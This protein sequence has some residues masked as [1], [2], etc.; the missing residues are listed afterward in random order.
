MLARCAIFTVQSVSM[1]GARA[2]VLCEG[3]LPVL[4]DNRELGQGRRHQV[5]R[6]ELGES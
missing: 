1:R 2:G 3:A 5:S 6:E 4:C